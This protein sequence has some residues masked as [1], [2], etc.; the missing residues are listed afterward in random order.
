[1]NEPVI[2]STFEHRSIRLPLSDLLEIEFQD[3]PNLI[4][5]VSLR[6][7]EFYTGYFIGLTRIAANRHILYVAPKY[8]DG[9]ITGSTDYLQMLSS[10]LRHPEV[11]GH[12]EKLFEIDFDS[13]PIN[14][15]QASDMITPLIVVQF[16]RSVR[17]IVQKGL[18][19]DYYNKT[20]N[21]KS[22][23]K[24][25][26]L[27]SRT[28][29]QNHLKQDKL[30]TWCTYQEFGLNNPQNRLLKTTLQFIQRF[31]ETGAVNKLN[32]EASLRFIKPAF[33]DID[34]DF[35]PKE[36]EHFK[37]NSFFSEY[38]EAVK[39]AKILLKRFGYQL[40]AV[41][42][43][44]K[45]SIPPFWI[46]MS[47]LFELYVL[48]KLKEILSPGEL[49]YQANGKFGEL[50]FLRTTK[51]E[52]IIIDAKYKPVYAKGGYDID[53]I[54]QLSAYARD[55]GLLEQLNIDRKDWKFTVLPCLII[56]PD[57]NAGYQLQKDIL[58]KHPIKEFERFFKAGINIPEIDI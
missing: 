7:G 22:S 41:R 57:K 13:E 3:Y 45:T 36:I 6:K 46:D 32:L 43:E 42:K 51:G 24:G 31:A 33:E 58:F 48:G 15:A 44:D 56:H 2:I 11:L 25:K 55:K 4:E 5:S 49:I 14:I 29:R 26:I 17:R 10:C 54:R 23:V 37:A 52:E 50:D 12:T 47:K 34:Q 38:S 39:L 9:V 16:L 30:H 18:Q 19:K 35:D 28:I 21:K 1:M 20:E 27:V 53:N 40:N 8:D